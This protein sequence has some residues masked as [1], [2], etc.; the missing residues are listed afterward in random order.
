MR[1]AL[2][3]EGWK[4]SRSRVPLVTALLLGLLLPSMGLGF[5][6]VALRGGTGILAD[7]A[8]SFLFAEGWVGYLRLV[9]QIAAV[10]AF[11]GVGVV[12][13]WV[14]GREH[15]DRTFA[16]LFS[17]AVSRTSIA[18][19]KFLVLVAWAVLVSMAVVLVS[20]AL[21]VVSG[22]GPI[23]DERL[24]PELLRLFSVTVG[25]SLLALTMALAAS[26]G[27]GYLPA[28]GALIVIVAVTQ[29]A[30]LFG[31]GAWFPY[32]IPGLTAVVG[33]VGV[34][35]VTPLQAGLVPLTALAGVM[36]TLLWWRKAQVV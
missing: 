26:W 22:V 3:V 23:Q 24:V 18:A 6:L 9:D 14:F 15:S 36:A 2:R 19:A 21:G 30:V 35:A 34:P 11:L 20:L 8:A 12:V 1:A 10:A 7:K 25:A 32:A 5:Y 27:R 29:V 16:A 28:I 17:L 4:L 13:A 31:T 33:G